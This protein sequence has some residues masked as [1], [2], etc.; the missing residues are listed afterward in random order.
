MLT[1]RQRSVFDLSLQRP[2]TLE[3]VPSLP[4]TPLSS[5]SLTPS[6]SGTG[7]LRSISRRAW[8]KSADDLS[9]ISG[10]ERSKSP[11]LAPLDTELHDKISKYRANRSDSVNSSV[12]PTTP[13][14]NNKQRKVD[15]PVVAQNLSSSPPN[16]NFLSTSGSAPH[17]LSPLQQTP[18]HTHSRSHSFTPRLASKFAPPKLALVPPSPSRKVSISS[19]NDQDQTTPSSA[20]RSAFPFGLGSS[21]PNTPVTSVHPTPP[22]KS[23]SVPLPSSPSLSPLLDPPKIIEPTDANESRESRRTSQI[24]H[25]SGFI[26]RLGSF[27][28]ATINQ[29]SGHTGPLSKGWKP[30][31]LILKGTK[32]YFYKP[33][34]DRTG[35]VKELF[36]TELVAAFEEAGL[37]ANGVDESPEVSPHRGG[38]DERRK[39]AYWGRRTHPE[40]VRAESD[41]R[42][43]LRGTLPALVHEAVFGTTFAS[44][45]DEEPLSSTRDIK[46][47]NFA[48]AILLGLPPVVGQGIFETEFLRCSDYLVS[49]A[50]DGRKK[51]QEEKVMMLADEYLTF[52]ERPADEDAWERWREETIPLFPSWRERQ[53]ATTSQIGGMPSSSS[54]QAMFVPTPTLGGEHLSPNLGTSSPRP[55]QS[56]SIQSI[57]EALDS[58]RLI[59]SPTS[60][61][62]ATQQN[63]HKAMVWAALERDGFTKEV[64]VRMD[65]HLITSSLKV[66]NRD[67]WERTPDNL[68]PSSFSGSEGEDAEGEEFRGFFGTEAH[69]H[70][71]TKTVLLQIFGQDTPFISGQV[72]SNTLGVG[73]ERPV[74]KSSSRA[75]VIMTWIRIGELSRQ[76]G[77]EC[78]WM[79]ICAA[80]FSRPVARLE[81][82]WKRLDPMALTIAE[83]WVYPGPEGGPAT[84]GEPKQTPWGG[85]AKEKL[86]ECFDQVK[87]SDGGKGW[88]VKPLFE[89]KE[90]W[91]GLKASFALCPRKTDW[92]RL[93]KGRGME[94]DESLSRMVALWQTLYQNKG[95]NGSGLALKITRYASFLRFL[96]VFCG[97][98]LTD[99]VFAHRYLILCRP[100]STS[101]CHFRSRRNRGGAARSSRTSGC[102][103]RWASNRLTHCSL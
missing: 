4:A 21:K 82:V 46:W 25:Q 45:E 71:L 96:I 7:D 76:L 88:V 24:I 34:N 63:Q 103:R 92:G 27:N 86:R 57:F 10:P 42:E 38:R 52:H 61:K 6:K 33:P 102:P 20:S 36:P 55:D 17:N 72:R 15:F 35:A 64:L 5:R 26:N 49:G 69:P 2:G 87:E 54:T 23:H 31:K 81:R 65:P 32:L 37:D 30:F 13:P 73:D 56:H 99:D 44:S 39:R 22:T 62:G 94:E 3:P 53:A 91:G 78:S 83:S 85:I 58:P 98:T 67:L 101:L 1:L 75:E 18:P 74:T 95:N 79:A 11:S 68:S 97:V 12:T 28:P 19:A 9:N 90:V 84:A 14:S 8:S 60:G 93:E 47:R 40:L 43:V 48:S 80:L 59:P 41:E 89:A 50:P 66:F 70:W 77:D 16:R 100:G 51:D 29:N